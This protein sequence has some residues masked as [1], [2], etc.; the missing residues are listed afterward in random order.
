MHEDTDTRAIDNFMVRLRRYIEDNPAE[1]F[2]LCGESVI[3]FC[4]SWAAAP[5]PNTF[6]PLSVLDGKG[7]LPD[8]SML[9]LLWV[10]RQSRYIFPRRKISLGC[11]AR[12]LLLRAPLLSSNS[13]VH[14]RTSLAAA[15]PYRPAAA[16]VSVAKLPKGRVKVNLVF[17]SWDRSSPAGTAEFSPGR[18]PG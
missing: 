7:R 15:L 5:R 11:Y 6:S 14:G 13:N 18:S 1:P 9:S 2:G 8:S 12:R 16:H 4:P 3:V 17:V 10:R